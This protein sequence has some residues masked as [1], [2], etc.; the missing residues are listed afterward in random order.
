MVRTTDQA[1]AVVLGEGGLL[2]TC[3]PGTTIIVMSTISPTAVQEMAAQAKKR[4]VEIMDSAVS[5]GRQ[6]AEAGT[7]SMMVGGDEATFQKMHPMLE[8]MG[9]NIFY[10]GTI[11]MGEAAKLANNLLLLIN[12]IAAYEAMALAEKLGLDQNLLRDLVKV[13]TGGSWVMEHWDMVTS[14]KE[15]YKPEGT[16]DLIYKDFQLASEVAQNRKV[17]LYLG[18][19]ASQLGRY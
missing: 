16:L 4:G 17:P 7:L 10:M 6:G 11:G 9:K 3:R 14:W 8:K 18:S 2:N 1:K 13:S 19:L 15:H 12:M 5:G